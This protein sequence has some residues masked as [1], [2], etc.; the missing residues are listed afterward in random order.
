MT[1]ATKQLTQALQ[2]LTSRS[3][4]VATKPQLA[5]PQV[6]TADR[7]QFSKEVEIYLEQKHAYSEKTRHVSVGSY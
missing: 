1:D 5:A 4:H 7:L 2:E 6:I 3:Q